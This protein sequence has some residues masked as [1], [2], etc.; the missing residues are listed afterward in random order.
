MCQSRTRICVP[1]RGA[2]ES[3]MNHSPRKTEGPE[4]RGRRECRVPNAPAAS[5]AKKKHTSVVTTVTPASPGIPCAMRFN[6][7]FR[8]L[9]GDRA[10]LS[11]SSS[12]Y[13]F[14]RAPVGPTSPP[15]DLPPASRR[16]DHTTSPSA[17]ASFVSAPDQSQASSTTMTSRAHRCRVHRISSS[18]RDDRDTQGTRQRGL[19]I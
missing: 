10:L 15:L 17:H 3:C 12:G 4:N 2:P 13:G 6:G 16:Q 11:P 1:R 5:R 19:W 7:L 8:T 18:V 14:V 9:P